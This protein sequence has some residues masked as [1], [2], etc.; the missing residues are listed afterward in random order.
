MKTK[1]SILKLLLCLWFSVGAIHAQESLLLHQEDIDIE[2][3]LSHNAVKGVTDDDLGFIWLATAYGLNRYDGYEVKVFTQENGLQNDRINKMWKIGSHHLWL[4]YPSSQIDVFN[5]HTNTSTPLKTILQKQQ[6]DF[7]PKDIITTHQKQGSS[8]IWIY[9]KAHLYLF[10]GIHITKKIDREVYFQDAQL[11][12]IEA[13]NKDYWALNQFDT[14]VWRF[15]ED[16]QVIDKYR[17][18]PI[19][20]D[21]NEVFLIKVFSQPETFAYYTFNGEGAYSTFVLQKGN[22]ILEVAHYNYNEWPTEWYYID[23]HRFFVGFNNATHN[24]LLLRDSLGKAMGEFLL[25]FPLGKFFI[26]KKGFAWAT[27]KPKHSGVSKLA[28]S[29][30]PFKTYLTK[31]AMMYGTRGISELSDSTIIITGNTFTYL[32]DKTRDTIYPLFKSHQ[33]IYD[34]YANFYDVLIDSASQDI[35]L[36]G[37]R[38]YLLS[39]NLSSKKKETYYY[40]APIPYTYP[41]L[42]QSKQGKIWVGYAAGIGEIDPAKKLVVPYALDNGFSTIHESHVRYFHENKQ[43][44]WVTSTKGIFL[45]K[46]QEGILAH[47]H[48]AAN[49]AK[50]RIPYDNIAHIYEEEGCFWLASK[51][52]GLIH[53]NPQTGEHQQYTTKDGLSHNVIYAIYP[54]DYGN[55]WISSDNGI[56]RFHKASKLITVYLPRDGISCQEFNTLSHYKAKDGTIYFGGIDGVTA[57]HPKDFQQDQQNNTLPLRVTYYAKRDET[58]GKYIEQTQ[59]LLETSNIVIEADERAFLLKFALLDFKN[60]KDNHYAYKIEGID[61]D[62]QY[63]KEN[64]IRSIGLPYGNYQLRIKGQGS[65]GYWV[66]YPKSIQIHVLRP[67]YLQSWFIG[68]TVISFILGIIGLIRFRTRQLRA[69]EQKLEQIVQERTAKIEKDKKVIEQQAEDLK[70]LDKLKSRFFA[71]ISHELRTPLTLILGPLSYL[72]EKPLDQETQQTLNTIEQNGKSLLSLVEEV[73]DLSKLDA[74]KLQLD[75]ET[76]HFNSFIQRIC[77]AFNSQALY[78]K[79]NYK[80]NSTVDETAHFFLDVSKFEKII[81]NLLSNALKFTPAGG[82]VSIHVAHQNEHLTIQVKDSGQGISKNDLPLIFNRFFQ[83][84]ETNR[85]AQGGTGVGLAL[86]KELIEFLNGNIHVESTVGQGTVF[87]IKLP[88]RLAPAPVVEM[89][90]IENN[91]I[92]TKTTRPSKTAENTNTTTILLV[93]D[94]SEMQKFVHHLLS[95]DYNVLTA[96]NG[97]VALEI[98]QQKAASIKLIISDVMMPVMDGFEFLQQVKASNSWRHIPMMMLTARAAEQDKFT[99]LSAGVDDYIL[100]PFS[101][102]ELKTRV[103]NLVEN[104]NAR[105]D[106]IL[107]QEKGNLSPPTK[108]ST[109]TKP[110]VQAKK[111]VQVSQ[112]EKVWLVKLERLVKEEL[113]NEE[114]SVSLLA[115]ALGISRRSLETK[116]KKLTGLTPLK[117]IQ[118][119]RLQTARFLLESG[120][121]DR[122][123]DACYQ[124]GFKNPHYF[125]QLFTKRFGK[126]P[127]NF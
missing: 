111:T 49:Q 105:L 42:F 43:G 25:D 89:Q 13:S 83:S 17:L 87:Y 84:T 18:H 40:A 108:V 94:N 14:V 66:E 113:D 54:D 28:F 21:S 92:K 32:L 127:K 51:G 106:W 104:N 33:N 6:L 68:L 65:G 82:T 29:S 39:Y 19:T 75:E 10:D 53:W 20:K 95:K 31:Q 99:A 91:V 126:S 85:P 78:Q 69:R 35:W 50:F 125:S 46:P 63:Q 16:G 115:T 119:I 3:G 7:T 74:N 24:R 23:T 107:E 34:S 45:F 117:Y 70:A 62:W 5:T 102:Q 71:N 12:A 38:D 98:L 55:L 81:N 93:E 80:L 15:G 44:I 4:E 121:V 123:A 97:A 76:I 61:K 58:S 118:E 103:R 109:A 112:T 37:H 41:T 48:S 47:Y 73:L 88:I 124:T 56:M 1:S 79:I 90:P 101:S 30:S 9:T 114:L 59:Q 96:N 86:V 26:D 11:D 120:E 22:Q 64:F 116:I 57:F 67:F 110:K 2:D 60:P 72:K 8:S 122:V 27:K 100:K 77:F 52:G 36:A